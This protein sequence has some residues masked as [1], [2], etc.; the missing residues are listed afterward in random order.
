MCLAST[1]QSSSLTRKVVV[2]RTSSYI[3]SLNAYAPV[4]LLDW[5]GYISYLQP[6]YTWCQPPPPR[7]LYDYGVMPYNRWSSMDCLHHCSYHRGGHVCI[8]SSEYGSRPLTNIF[9]YA[10]VRS[11]RCDSHA[12]GSAFRT[13]CRSNVRGLF[14]SLVYTLL[15]HTPYMIVVVS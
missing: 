6:T 9:R 14:L 3:Q 15:L 11:T 7:S 2:I 8:A 13:L 5:L 10:S 12:R 1:R 4:Y